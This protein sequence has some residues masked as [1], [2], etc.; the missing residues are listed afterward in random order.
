MFRF[1][2][3]GGSV[4]LADAINGS[5]SYHVVAADWE[6]DVA[7]VIEA[8]PRAGSVRRRVGYLDLWHGSCRR[9]AW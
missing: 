3:R 2:T 5:A 7:F 1:P 4:P 6:G 9:G 8:G